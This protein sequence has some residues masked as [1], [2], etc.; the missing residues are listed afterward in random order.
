MESRYN[1]VVYKTLRNANATFSENQNSNEKRQ[2]YLHIVKL[3]SCK[4]QSKEL[5][6]YIIHSVL[7]KQM[8]T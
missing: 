6:S 7:K 1:L 5:F 2:K 8:A 4:I 3:N